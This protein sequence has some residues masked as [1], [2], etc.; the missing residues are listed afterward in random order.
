VIV[1]E[2]GAVHNGGCRMAKAAEPPVSI[3]VP[4]R[5]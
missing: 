4:M 1:M 2:A 5:A 3:V